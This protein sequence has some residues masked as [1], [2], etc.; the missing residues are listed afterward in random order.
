MVQLPLPNHLDE[1]KILHAVDPKKDVDGTHIMTS[2]KLMVGEAGFKP[3][4]PKGILH[5]IK[6][7]GV[8]IA[9]KN[10]VIAGRSNIVGKPV[11]ML[12]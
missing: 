10:V 7:T 6:S 9:G 11:A 12:L 3:C 8:D 4:T 1:L 2:G 5:M